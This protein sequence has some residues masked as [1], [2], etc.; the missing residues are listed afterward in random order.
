VVVQRGAVG[1]GE[2]GLGDEE[3]R[4]P[5]H[6]RPQPPQPA[7]PSPTPSPRRPGPRSGWTPRAGRRCRSAPARP[8]PGSWPATGSLPPAGHGSGGRWSASPALRVERFTPPPRNSGNGRATVPGR[9]FPPSASERPVRSYSRA[10]ARGAHQDR[11]RQAD[12]EQPM[13]VTRAMIPPDRPPTGHRQGW[14][15]APPWRGRP[16][17]AFHAG[18]TGLDRWYRREP[19]TGGCARS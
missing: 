16:A 19:G 9:P 13:E 7:P 1:P 2:V 17:P 3:R 10:S 14:G 5:V 4:D 6:H 8:P 15:N 18:V 11:H 12:P